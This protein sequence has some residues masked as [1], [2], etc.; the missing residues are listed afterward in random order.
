MGHQR[1]RWGNNMRERFL[2]LFPE[3][4]KL[5]DKLAGRQTAIDSLQATIIRLS[6][7]GHQLANDNR[8]LA[9]IATKNRELAERLAA[10]TAPK[11]T[12]KKK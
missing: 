1:R 7:E 10:Q 8:R 6:K 2:M 11:P 5:K 3:Y 9:E 12:R 4:R